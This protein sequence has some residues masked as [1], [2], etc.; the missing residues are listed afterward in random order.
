MPAI[1]PGCA[2]QNLTPSVAALSG[3]TALC[4]VALPKM[5]T[6]VCANGALLAEQAITATQ[7][8]IPGSRSIRRDGVPGM[9]TPPGPTS[10]VGS[11]RVDRCIVDLSTKAMK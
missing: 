10:K 4:G 7:A 2:L 6:A 11:L 8:K 9:E 1:V 3:L 5:L